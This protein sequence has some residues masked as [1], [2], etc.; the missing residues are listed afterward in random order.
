MKL[1][2]DPFIA[3]DHVQLA[4]PAGGEERARTF[5]GNILQMTE[6]AKPAAL[7][8]RGGVW[9]QS[10]DVMVHLGVDQDFKAARKAHPAFRC[11]DFE[12]VTQRLR[13]SGYEVVPDDVK[14][15]GALRIYTHDPF[16]NRL[17]LIAASP[18]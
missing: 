7:S 3:I 8:L 11:T 13:E 12:H 4:M 6:I 1:S 17:E 2:V 5:Y 10:G 18:G 16:G 15:A 9:F 14:L